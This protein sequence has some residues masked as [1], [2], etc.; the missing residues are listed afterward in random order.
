LRDD[1]EMA[2]QVTLGARPG[3]LRLPQPEGP[4]AELGELEFGDVLGG[5]FRIKDDEGNT[6]AIEVVVGNVASLSDDELTVNANDG[7]ERTFTI[8]DDTVMP[9]RPEVGDP[10]VVVTLGDSEDARLVLPGGVFHLQGM[11]ERLREHVRE[12]FIPPEVPW[13]DI[14]PCL[15][16]RPLEPMPG[17]SFRLRPEWSPELMPLPESERSG[18]Y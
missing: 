6:L 1:E 10:I 3:P 5:E 17:P 16:E 15:E 2:L 4:F 12:R 13:L 14:P 8:T 7:S 9:Q 18:D 11:F